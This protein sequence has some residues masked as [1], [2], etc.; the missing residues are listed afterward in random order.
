MLRPPAMPRALLL[1]TYSL[2]FRSFHALPMMNT[3]AGQPTNALYGFMSL[4]IKLWREQK[5]FGT[6]FGLD[7]PKRTFRHELYP[8]YKAERARAPEPLVQQLA[9]LDVLLE[10]TGLPRFRVPGFEADDVLAT[11]ASELESQGDDVLVVSG[12][13]DLLQLVTE[14]THV[15]F[16]GR[17]GKDSVLYDPAKVKERFGIPASRLPQ[18]I[19]LVGDTSDN[20]PGVPGIGPGTAAKLLAEHVSI[21]DLVANLDDQA[22]SIRA[23]LRPEAER[24]LRNEHLATLRRDVPLP[25]GPRVGVLPP[26]AFDALFELFQELEFKSLITRLEAIKTPAA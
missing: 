11:L 23:K 12:D 22:E 2:F 24:M 13:R 5:P 10:K 16:T 15:L 4:L 9:V 25:D 20:I 6:A 17:R 7:A 19:A 14:K 26:S 3:Q 1:D 21:A 18:Y 8:E